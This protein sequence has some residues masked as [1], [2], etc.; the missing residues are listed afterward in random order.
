MS[1]MALPC[2]PSAMHLPAVTPPQTLRHLAAGNPVK[3]RTRLREKHLNVSAKNVCGKI[4]ARYF[5]FGNEPST[6]TKEGIWM[7]N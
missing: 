3:L 1:D 2:K 4:W 6:F 5:E 7:A